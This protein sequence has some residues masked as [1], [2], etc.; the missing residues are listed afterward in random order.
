VELL[1][2]SRVFKGIFELTNLYLTEYNAIL[3]NASKER[4][5]PPEYTLSSTLRGHFLFILLNHC[6]SS[7]YSFEPALNWPF[8][9]Q[10]RQ[11]TFK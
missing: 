10:H 2:T 11:L 3:A 7:D 6:P 1:K 9:H 8:I 5:E 4:I